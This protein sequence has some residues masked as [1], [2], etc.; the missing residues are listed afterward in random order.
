MIWW[1]VGGVALVLAFAVAF[2][3]YTYVEAFYSPVR[4]R[5]KN[6]ELPEGEQYEKVSEYMHSLISDLEAVPSERVSIITFDGLRLYGRYYHVADGAPLQIQFHGYRGT[7]IRDFCGGCRIAR[8]S[9]YNVLLVDQRAQGESEGKTICFGLKEKFDLVKWVEYANARFGEQTKI[10][11]VGVSM[12]GATVLEATELELPKNV[13][14]V[15]ADSP[16]SSPEEIMSSVCKEKGFHPKF[17]MP[18]LKLGARVF[19][20]FKVEGGA[21]EAVKRSRLPVL[22]IHGEDDRYVPVEMGKKV[23]EA[24]TSR[25]ML[26]IAPDAAHGISFISDPKTYLEK[27]NEFLKTVL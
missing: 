27:V 26:Y 3:L 14:G 25:K 10:V 5:R 16:F 20:K 12:G 19:G 8:E 13:V 11:L 4:R 2:T 24:C 18:F 9:G 23:Y 1:I 7:P 17:A 6:H 22:I 15:I 21:V